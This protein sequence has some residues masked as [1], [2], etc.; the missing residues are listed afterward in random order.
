M[1]NNKLHAFGPIAVLEIKEI[2]N[3]SNGPKH[4][5]N[6]GQ[7]HRRSIAAEH[8]IVK[9]NGKTAPGQYHQANIEIIVDED[10]AIEIA[11]ARQ[12]FSPI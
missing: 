3:Q 8:V 7:N 5:N 2:D 6:T 4:G 1:P 9:H 10:L 11:Q 12:F